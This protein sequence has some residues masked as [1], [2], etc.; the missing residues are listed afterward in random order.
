MSKRIE[1]KELKERLETAFYNGYMKAEKE[2]LE[3]IDN[4]IIYLKELD[5]EVAVYH[6]EKLKQKITGEE[7]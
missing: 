6:M 5:F 7:K 4:K 1:D 2:F 3:L